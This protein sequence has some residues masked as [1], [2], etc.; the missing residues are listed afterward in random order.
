[1][2]SDE[3]LFERLREGAL[4]AFDLLYARYERRLFGFLLGYVGERTEAEDLFHEAFIALLRDAPD[5]LSTGSVRA[6]LY[7]TA[8]NAALNR[9]RSRARGQRAFAVPDATPPSR[10]AEE[11]MHAAEAGVALER[12]VA[13]LQ[14]PLAE[15]YRLRASGL[16]YEE[17]A[18][19]LTI[20]VGTVKSRMHEMVSQLKKEMSPWTAR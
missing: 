7:Q 4:D 20:P 1:V 12:A 2:E 13:R 5:A 11:Q 3:R 6:W 14:A 16:S 18:V 19:V 8:R 17:M 10:S 15:L 9:L